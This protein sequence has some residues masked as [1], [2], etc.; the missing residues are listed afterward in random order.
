MENCSN[1]KNAL[2]DEIWG[3]YKCKIDK[4]HHYFDGQAV[5]AKCSYH[6]KGTPGIAR[7]II[8]ERM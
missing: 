5:G 3:E 4:R 7:P 6:E 8:E 2:F 1:C